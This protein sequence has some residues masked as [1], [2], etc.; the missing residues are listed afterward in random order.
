MA[1]LPG[2]SGAPINALVVPDLD[3]RFLEGQLLNH[4]APIFTS[5]RPDELI[6]D[7]FKQY[8]GHSI[9]NS[10]V[11]GSPYGAGDDN[12]VLAYLDWVTRGTASLRIAY[13]SILAAAGWSPKASCATLRLTGRAR[14][15]TV[16]PSH[17]G[18]PT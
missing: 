8:R 7:L 14:N 15:R 3:G 16:F 18:M 1:P 11:V 4:N 12:S 10:L 6:F 9:S 2:S 17:C 5:G 13:E